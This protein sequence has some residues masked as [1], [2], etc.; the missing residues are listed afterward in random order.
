MAA[1]KKERAVVI[2]TEHRGVFF[3]YVANEKKAPAEIELEKARMCVYW[4]SDVKGV[5]G[6][7]ATGPTKG[8][9][10]THSIPKFTAYKVTGILE[11]SPEAVE[12]WEKG[13]WA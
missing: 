8:C 10:V 5:L 12:A 6:L 13:A 9:R 3:G 2:T 11:C 4:S 7:A 1:K